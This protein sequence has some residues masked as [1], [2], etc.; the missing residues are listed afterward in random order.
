MKARLKREE[1]VV[2]V[3]MRGQLEMDKFFQNFA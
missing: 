3:K 2:G 1:K